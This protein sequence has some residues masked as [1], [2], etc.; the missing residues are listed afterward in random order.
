MDQAEYED[1]FHSF[2]VEKGALSD[3]KEA[4]RGRSIGE[5][6]GTTPSL[7]WIDAGFL[8]VDFPRQDWA[9]LHEEWGLLLGS[10]DQ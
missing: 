4:M 9:S 2:L 6:L 5:F 7:N 1:M 3:W 10:N 8:W